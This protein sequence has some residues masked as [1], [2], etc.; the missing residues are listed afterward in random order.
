MHRLAKGILIASVVFLAASL[1]PRAQ[2]QAFTPNS[3]WSNHRGWFYDHYDVN[4]GLYRSTWQFY[5]PRYDPALYSPYQGYGTNWY[6]RTPYVL[7]EYAGRDPSFDRG[8]VFRTR[9][10]PDIVYTWDRPVTLT[11]N[12]TLPPAQAEDNVRASIRMVQ[13]KVIDT[14][15]RPMQGAVGDVRT[16]LV[17]DELTGRRTFVDFGPTSNLRAQNVTVS[18]G[19][20][21]QVN[22][23]FVKVGPDWVFKAEQV[24]TETTTA[25]IGGT[26]PASP[27]VRPEEERQLRSGMPDLR[28]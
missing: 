16:A 17:E 9:V 12:R 20:W 15:T 22:G 21:I 5:R 26:V 25:Q 7:D 3:M 13:G 1:T 11:T 2:A 10:G 6:A 14:S 24:R 18:P 23:R 8:V 19:N 28:R 4:N 27:V